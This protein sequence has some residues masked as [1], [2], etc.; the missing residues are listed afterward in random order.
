MGL[1]A[2]GGADC[3]GWGWLQRVGLTA[4]GG[5]DCRGWGWLQ[6]VGL[7]AEGG[8]DCIAISA[9]ADP[10]VPS[11]PEGT[12]EQESPVKAGSKRRLLGEPSSVGLLPKRRSTR[13]GHW[14]CGSAEC[15][16]CSERMS[17]SV[18]GVLCDCPLPSPA[19][20]RSRPS[21]DQLKLSS[22]VTALKSFFQPHD[23]GCSTGWVGG[24]AETQW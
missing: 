24:A 8:A 11:G 19:V 20:A 17:R 10:Q 5:A 22:C 18:C 3:R 12:V 23:S 4:E 16:C 13:V 7:T 6:R 21:G 14:G 1:T 2:E 9:C 15:V